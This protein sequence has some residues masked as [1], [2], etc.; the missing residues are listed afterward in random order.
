MITVLKQQHLFFIYCVLGSFAGIFLVI[1]EGMAP[2]FTKF[3]KSIEGKI[4]PKTI[5]F[6]LLL[7]FSLFFSLSNS[8]RSFAYL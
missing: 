2:L 7:F 4:L 5:I 1:S 6:V 8:T 3:V